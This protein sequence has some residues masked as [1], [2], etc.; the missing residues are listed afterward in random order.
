MHPTT[1]RIIDLFH[2]NGNSQYGHEAVTQ[3]QHGLQAAWMAEKEGASSELISAALL[4]DVGHLLHDLPDDAPDQGIDDR[5]E[6]LGERWLDRHF[7]RAVVEPVRLHVDAKRYLCAVESTYLSLL[8]AP[9]V[10]SLHLQGGPMNPAEIAEFRTHPF[11]EDAVRL[12]RWDD[13]AKDPALVTPP[14]EHF[15]SH[16]DAAAAA[17]ATV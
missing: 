7:T 1:K 2:A 16:L 6:V 9:S 5:H 4:H 11:H 8:S 10:Q 17:F 13:T 14:I 15:A 12:R 3:L